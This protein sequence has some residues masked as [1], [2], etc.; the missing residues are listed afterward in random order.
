MSKVW[1]AFGDSITDMGYYIDSAAKTAN[2][3]ATA[4]G[5]SGW[6]LGIDGNGYGSLQ[7]A[8]E[9][10]FK[11]DVKP[12]IVSIFAG[13]NDFGHST[14]VGPMWRGLEYILGRIRVEF[15]EAKILLITPLQRDFHDGALCG[16]T[17]GLGPN[18]M[19]RYLEEYADA[20]K[21]VGVEQ[22]IQVLDLYHD[23]PVTQ[24]NAWDYT[25]DGLHPTVEYGVE[26]GKQIGEALVKMVC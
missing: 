24:A 7:D 4:F 2:V 15:P 5:Y 16:E 13:T 14:E 10:M 1:F 6:S 3:V 19:D 21:K 12:D 25:I 26:L 18:K 9:D 23:S 22:Q 8:C 17:N 20:I 11:A